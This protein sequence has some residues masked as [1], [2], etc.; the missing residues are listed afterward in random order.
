MKTSACENVKNSAHARNFEF[1]VRHFCQ[2]MPCS[3]QIYHLPNF[4]SLSGVVAQ[5]YLGKG[6]NFQRYH[7][8][9]QTCPSRNS[10]LLRPSLNGYLTPLHV[11]SEKGRP[12]PGPVQRLPMVGFCLPNK[13]ESG[14]SPHAPSQFLLSG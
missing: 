12:W 6:S 9:S 2:I 5:H 11:S 14:M 1:F 8:T 3:S 13:K 10:T 7:M 4:L